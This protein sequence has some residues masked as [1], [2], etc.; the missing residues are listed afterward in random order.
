MKF[1]YKE[2]IYKYYT[3]GYMD[4]DSIKVIENGIYKVWTKTITYKDS[5]LVNVDSPEIETKKE[6]WVINCKTMKFDTLVGGID[7]P[8]IDKL[9]KNIVS[10]SIPGKL[11]EILCR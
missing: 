7:D 9:E 8:T 3:E 10:D 2:K 11:A 4:K 6:L 1:T 5:K